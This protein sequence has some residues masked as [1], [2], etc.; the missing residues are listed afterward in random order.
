MDYKADLM[1]IL[2]GI[3]DKIRETDYKKYKEVVDKSDRAISKPFM[4]FLNENCDIPYE[5]E[6]AKTIYTVKKRN[7]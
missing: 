2:N 6:S 5:L 7:W 4:D 3:K 1:A